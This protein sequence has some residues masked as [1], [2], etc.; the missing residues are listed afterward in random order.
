MILVEQYLNRQPYQIVQQHKRISFETCTGNIPKCNVSSLSG[1][2]DL[3]YQQFSKTADDGKGRNFFSLCHNTPPV[4]IYRYSLR[5]YIYVSSEYNDKLNET[6]VEF[7]AKDGYYFREFL[8]NM[9]ADIKSKHEHS[10]YGQFKL[11]DVTEQCKIIYPSLHNGIAKVRLVSKKKNFQT[12][13]FKDKSRLLMMLQRFQSK[14][15]YP[16]QISMENKL[17][18]LLYGPPGT[19]KTGTISAIANY[20]QRDLI[21]VNLSTIQTKEQLDSIMSSNLYD[22][23]KYIFVFE[24]IDVVL[25]LIQEREQIVAHDHHPSTMKRKKK[26]SEEE[27]DL[28]VVVP[29]LD[30]A[31]LLQLFDGVDSNEDRVIIVTTNF[32][33]QIDQALLRPGRIDLKLELGNCTHD[34]IHDLLQSYFE[35]ETIPMEQVHALPVEKFTPSFVIN[36]CVI[37]QTLPATLHFLTS[38]T[39]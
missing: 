25:H 37:H 27:N 30:L 33:N 22:V 32:P 38:H 1:E 13:F 31:H 28:S 3:L 4:K 21:M 2:I 16:K 8:K 19:G 7:R 23:K 35:E 39:L 5:E 18:I 10:Q 34:M 17:G 6:V 9:L 11:L 15:M 36:C 26:P 24:E 12:L 14:T 29:D 20:L